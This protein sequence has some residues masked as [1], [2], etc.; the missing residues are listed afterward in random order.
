MQAHQHLGETPTTAALNRPR[1]RYLA[2][3]RQR[4][5][6][7]DLA[8]DILQEALLRALRAA[9]DVQTDDQLAAW[10]YR[11]LRNA[12]VDTYRRRGVQ[13]RHTTPLHDDLELPDLSESDERSL[14]DCFRAL[15]PALR[16]DY[17]TV[18]SAV[19]LDG[20]RPAEV[21][22]ELG[23]TTNNLNVRRHRARQALR[24]LLETTCRV[25]A[26]HGCLD[27]TCESAPAV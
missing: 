26:D 7:P 1:A 15:L 2:F 9:P 19:D 10:F 3:V 23:L 6:D 17:A 8:E 22:G 14:C 5:S 12:I 13:A 4:I 24:E 18:L 21:A 16:P 11:V 25:C 20:R 27:C